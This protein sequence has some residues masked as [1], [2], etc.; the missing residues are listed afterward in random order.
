MP[1]AELYEL[2]SA[3]T[4]QAVNTQRILDAA[5]QDEMGR[6][7]AIVNQADP[8]WREMLKPL[9]PQRML[10]REFSIS[11]AVSLVTERDIEFRVKAFPIN[12]NYTL[13]H[14]LQYENESRVEIR[15]EQAPI[16]PGALPE[17]KGQSHAK[18]E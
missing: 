15:V 7:V 2:I 11:S 17:Q 1:V 9:A 13:R 16:V 6:F 18:L 10:M 8:E 5:Y 3:L 4:V 12:L 14:S